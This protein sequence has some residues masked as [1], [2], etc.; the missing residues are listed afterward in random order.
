MSDLWLW[1]AVSVSSG[2]AVYR[3]V[4]ALAAAA[5]LRRAVS[6][7]LECQ[8]CG[9][10]SYMGEGPSGHRLSRECDE[11]IGC[12][13]TSVL[14]VTRPQCPHC[15]Q[16]FSIFAPSISKRTLTGGGEIQE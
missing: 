10:V 2:Y 1:A 11:C 4:R 13:S 15:G 9:R 12:S 5:T 6:W 14:P 7:W 16:S 8:D 3:V